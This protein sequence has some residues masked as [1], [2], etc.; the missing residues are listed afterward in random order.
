M[1]AESSGEKSQTMFSL[2]DLRVKSQKSQTLFS[3]SD[4]ANIPQ[5]Q[6]TKFAESHPFALSWSHYL[7]L[8][9][10]YSLTFWRCVTHIFTL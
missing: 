2:L 8:F 6:Q 7:S 5:I 4:W 10:D 3:F 9:V 1:A